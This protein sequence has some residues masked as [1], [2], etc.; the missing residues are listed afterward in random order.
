MDH[1]EKVEKVR[2][3]ADVTYEEA[4]KAL[5]ESGWDMLDALVKLEAGGKIKKKAAEAY[6]T[7]QESPPDEPQPAREAGRQAGSGPNA[8]GKDKVEGFFSRLGKIIGYLV[9]K[10]CENRLIAKRHGKQIL[11]L[12]VIAFI[13]LLLLGFWGVIPLMIIS[14]FFDF[15]YGFKGP[16]LGKENINDA[17][18]YASKAA[19]NLKADIKSDIE[20]ERDKNE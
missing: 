5:E 19:D 7:G 6:T 12:P 2:A 16:E 4:K 1:L 13:I 3:Q 18:D 11:E 8:E 20:K 15:S 10:G 17:M 9:K 14:L